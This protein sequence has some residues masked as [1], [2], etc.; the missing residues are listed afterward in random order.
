IF[1]I[2]ALLESTTGVTHFLSLNIRETGVRSIIY[3]MNPLNDI[4]YHLKKN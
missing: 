4:L 1:Y 3:A 2:Q